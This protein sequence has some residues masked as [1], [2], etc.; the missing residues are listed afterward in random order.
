MIIMN[1]TGC[2]FTQFSIIDTALYLH[3]TQD[4]GMPPLM[5]LWCLG[6]VYVEV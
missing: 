3:Y 1:N 6:Y 2:T 5:A 4:C